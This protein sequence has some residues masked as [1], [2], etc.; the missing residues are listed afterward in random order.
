MLTIFSFFSSGNQNSLKLINQQFRVYEVG[1]GPKIN[2]EQSYFLIVAITITDEID[3][4][5]GIIL[6]YT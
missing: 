3:R 6:L 1:C 2:E 4:I 5:K